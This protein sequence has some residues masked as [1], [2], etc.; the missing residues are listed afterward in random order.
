MKRTD[1][2]YDLPEDLIAQHPLEQRSA[3]RL[4]RFD[5]HNG[6]LENRVFSDLPG[7]LNAGDLLVFN[8]T[9]VIPARLHGKKEAGAGLKSWL[10]G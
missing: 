9:E 2:H 7:L 1:F 6:D 3:S 5:R 4:L 10:N 8:N